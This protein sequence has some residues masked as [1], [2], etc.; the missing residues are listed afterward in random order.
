LSFSVLPGSVCSPIKEFTDMYRNM[1][2]C[3]T[4]ICLFAALSKL[5]VPEKL[6]FKTCLRLAGQMPTNCRPAQRVV[7]LL[8]V[9]DEKKNY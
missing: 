8:S 1:L 7:F 5:G 2:H 9:A 3:L 4:G 6:H